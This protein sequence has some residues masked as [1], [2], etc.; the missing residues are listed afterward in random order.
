[1]FLERFAALAKMIE[2]DGARL[3][4]G[5][6]LMLRE[7]AARDGLAVDAALV[8]EVNRLACG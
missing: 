8:E 4:G 3:P 2:S 5:R 6:R 1:V 7:A